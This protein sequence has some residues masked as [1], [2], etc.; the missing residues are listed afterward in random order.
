MDILDNMVYYALKAIYVGKASNTERA[1]RLNNIYRVDAA[2]NNYSVTVNGDAVTGTMG[3]LPQNNSGTDPYNGTQVMADM[4]DVYLNAG[5]N[6]VVF[7]NSGSFMYFSYLKFDFLTSELLTRD[8]RM[9]SRSYT[10]AYNAE[11]GNAELRQDGGNPDNTIWQVGGWAEYSITIAEPGEY[12]IG[13]RGPP[14]NLLQPPAA[15]MLSYCC[16]LVQRGISGCSII[17]LSSK[18]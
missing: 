13:G 3:T 15:R 17:Q 9:H 5:A 7:K 6:T 16:F 2:N 1:T 14:G 18:P 4:C 10:N 12:Q 8:I 11:N